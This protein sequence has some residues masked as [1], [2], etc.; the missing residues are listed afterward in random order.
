MKFP[1]V[2]FWP[3]LGLCVSLIAPSLGQVQKYLGNTG[4]IV[5]IFF[6]F[7]GVWVSCAYFLPKFILKFPKGNTLYLTVVTLIILAVV[8][9]LVYP[10]VNSGVIGGGSDRDEDV[11][12]AARALLK[13]EYPY[14]LKTYLGNSITHLPGSLILASP[15]VLLG[16]G[17]YQNLFWLLL[18]VLVSGF[19][20]KDARLGLFLLGLLVFF[21]PVV[22]QE[23]ITGGD[24][25]S[26]GIYI[27]L[28]ILLLVHSAA[29][30]GISALQK[31]LAAVL[32]GVALSS[33]LNFIFI[34][35]L[36]FS[37]MA[38]K[39]GWKSALI[40][41]GVVVLVFLAVTL[42]YYFHDPKS[43]TPFYG[44]YGKLSQFRHILPF[45]GVIVPLI[46]CA[47]A[48]VLS[49]QRMKEGYAIMLRNCALVQASFVM[50]AVVLDTQRSGRLQCIL[51]G[52]GLSFLFFGVLSAWHKL[53]AK[54]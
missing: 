8:F 4:V 14:H 48:L 30:P 50:W 52:Y 29:G 19:Y 53:T 24:L 27:V 18:F 28:F 49:F 25:L 47:L 21:S 38:Q 44:Q 1:P 40:Y 54:K 45:S 35:P 41:I 51:S 42:P 31:A 23:F 16:N 33:R 2:K 17:A 10:I 26:N 11:T 13:G 37:S 5:Y 6:V 12:I 32:L 22:L 9:F 7:S 34:L 20:L 36:V 15:F 3:F 46:G 43:F 39:S